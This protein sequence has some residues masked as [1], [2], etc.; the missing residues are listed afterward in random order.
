M[1]KSKVLGIVLTAIGGCA[2]ITTLMLLV[3]KMIV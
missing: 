1:I 3:E 2:L